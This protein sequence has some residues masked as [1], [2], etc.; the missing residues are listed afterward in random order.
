[1][2]YVGVG[3]GMNSLIRP[4]LYGAY[5]DIVNLTRLGKPATEL[6]TIV[7][8]ICETGRSA[9]LGS[10]ASACEGERRAARRQRRSL[11]LRDELALQPA[12]ARRRSHD[13][14]GDVASHGAALSTH[15]LHSWTSHRAY[16]G[17]RNAAQA[18]R[19]SVL[20]L[21]PK[22]AHGTLRERHRIR[23]P[24]ARGR[25]VDGRARRALAAAPFPGARRRRSDRARGERNHRAPSAYTTPARPGCFR[26]TRAPRSKCE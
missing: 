26:T 24:E 14:N 12:R 4:A 22:G 13:L 10:A 9:R 25:R 23:I 3:T 8:P 1:M 17:T 21:L 20:F 18:L 2:Q 15:R 6:V 7:G 19:T 11:R 16:G 5:H